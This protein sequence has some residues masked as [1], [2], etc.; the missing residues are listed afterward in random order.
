MFASPSTI[1]TIIYMINLIK[2][3]TAVALVI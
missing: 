3:A 2:A 1:I